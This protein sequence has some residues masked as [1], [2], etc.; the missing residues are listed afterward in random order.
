[1][2]FLG[3]QKSGA[4]RLWRAPTLHSLFFRI[5]IIA[6]GIFLLQRKRKDV[7]KLIR[8]IGAIPKKEERKEYERMNEWFRKLQ[9]E[10]THCK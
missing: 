10:K 8:R 2:S 3:L 6:L 7:A 5:I 4:R 9:L 1:M